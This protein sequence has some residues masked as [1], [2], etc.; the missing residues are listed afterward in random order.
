MR[1]LS[2]RL[3]QKPRLCEEDHKM[4]HLVVRGKQVYKHIGGLVKIDRQAEATGPTGSG[5]IAEW[6]ISCSNVA[7]WLLLLLH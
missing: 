6:C 2:D 7:S 1:D 4:G 3:A 5:G